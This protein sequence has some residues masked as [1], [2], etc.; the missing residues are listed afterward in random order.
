MH[1]LQ[2]ETLSSA[3]SASF[4]VFLATVSSRRGSTMGLSDHGHLQHHELLFHGFLCTQP[5]LQKC[6]WQIP[7]K[8]AREYFPPPKKNRFIMKHLS[9][10]SGPTSHI[11]C[12]NQ[13]SE[14]GIKDKSC[15]PVPLTCGLIPHLREHGTGRKASSDR[16]QRV[17]HR[18]NLPVTHPGR[19]VAGSRCVFT[20]AGFIHSKRYSR[21]LNRQII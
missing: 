10:V 9:S 2:R 17:T 7:D 5:F 16:A 12:E 11:L 20:T 3:P 14:T 18:E 8:L 13:L 19:E 1:A 15:C 21:D 4:S 6:H